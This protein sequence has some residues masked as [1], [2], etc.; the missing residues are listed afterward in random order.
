MAEGA[1]PDLLTYLRR[2]DEG[3]HKIHLRLD[4]VSIR[5]SAIEEHLAAFHRS[6][7]HQN[8][9]ITTLVARLDRIERR[10]DLAGAPNEA[11]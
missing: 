7:A 6:I 3:L 11:D 10:L 8:T 4:D 5:M 1:D 2:L 9:E